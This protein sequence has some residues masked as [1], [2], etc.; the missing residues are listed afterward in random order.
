MAGPTLAWLCHKAGLA[1]YTITYGSQAESLALCLDICGS[2]FGNF[3]GPPTKSFTTQVRGVDASVLTLEDFDGR[4]TSA[5]EVS[6]IED[7]RRYLARLTSDHLRVADLLAI[8]TS[9]APIPR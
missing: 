6:W 1:Q 8:V 3:R 4:G 2:E 9:L 7:S 5:F